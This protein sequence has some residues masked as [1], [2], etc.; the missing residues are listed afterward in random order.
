MNNPVIQFDVTNCHLPHKSEV[1]PGVIKFSTLSIR[2]QDASTKDDHKTWAS[3]RN[4]WTSVT[5]PASNPFLEFLCSFA[6]RALGTGLLIPICMFWHWTHD[7]VTKQA[8]LFRLST[9]FLHIIR[10]IKSIP[11]KSVNTRKH[12]CK[13]QIHTTLKSICVRVQYCHSN[14]ILPQI[15]CSL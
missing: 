11:F 6:L 15:L 9:S 2:K 10:S 5:R 4:P 12:Y 3:R 1:P 8:S 14:S 7:P 13:D